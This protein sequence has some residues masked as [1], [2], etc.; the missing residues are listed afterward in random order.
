MLCT[1]KRDILEVS[2]NPG[3]SMSVN[4]GVSMSMSV[5]PGVI[6]YLLF[7]FYWT[8]QKIKRNVCNRSALDTSRRL[9]SV[10]RSTRI[11]GIFLEIFS[12]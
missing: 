3:V 4:P 10:S 8:S 7:D 9:Q 2:V 6:C 1:S 5:N 11:K 12:S